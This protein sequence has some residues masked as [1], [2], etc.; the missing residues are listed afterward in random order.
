[1]ATTEDTTIPLEPECYYHIFNR[2][3]NR[4]NIFHTPPNYPYFLKK[5][6]HYLS[7]YLDT[8]CFCLLPNHF[9]LLV[10][11]KPEEHI[12]RHA[13]ATSRKSDPL[14]E[15]LVSEQFRRLFLSYSK[16][17]NRQT[18]RVGSVFQK[19]FRRKKVTGNAYF[20]GLVAYIHRNPVHHR[21]HNDYQTYPWSSYPRILADRP[22]KLMRQELLDWFGS[23][24][25]YIDFH[26][27]N[28]K[29]DRIESLVME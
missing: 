8:Y 9:H 21:V 15:Q 1:M 20:T 6:D 25:S 13:R 3:N 19:P 16:A 29:P 23:R 28:L 14:A 24:R 26:R 12:V 4:Q 22:S 7:G 5:Y 17:I 2:G 27:T 11:I 10:R 18:G